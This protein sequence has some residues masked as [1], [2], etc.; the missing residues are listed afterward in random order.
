M[1]TDPPKVHGAEEYSMTDSVRAQQDQDFFSTL[2][3]VE[4]YS[5]SNGTGLFRGPR[6]AES[7][8]NS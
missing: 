3:I 5:L 8:K 4:T 6:H 2:L 1:I 7:S